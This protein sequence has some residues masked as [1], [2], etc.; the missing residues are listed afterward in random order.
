MLNDLPN[1]WY[2][3]EE[4]RGDTFTWQTLREIFIKDFFFTL[5]DKKLKP[6]GKQIQQ[7]LGT[8]SLEKMAENNPTKEC[9]QVL[10]RNPTFDSTIV[11]SRPFS[12]EELLA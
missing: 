11:R 9:R 7:F 2:K 3:I 12:R 10:V 4:S 6:A 8:N 1:K 5:D